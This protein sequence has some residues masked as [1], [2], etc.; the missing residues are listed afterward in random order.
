[1]G[2]Q[3]QRSNSITSVE[4]DIISREELAKSTEVTT[5]A[6]GKYKLLVYNKVAGDKELRL[7]NVERER[8][9]HAQEIKSQLDSHSPEDLQKT[10]L[11]T[12][13]RAESKESKAIPVTGRGGL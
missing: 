6:A 11:G 10:E 7:N 2:L 1:M 13:N 3:K 9:P 4:R 12:D 5:E 8:T